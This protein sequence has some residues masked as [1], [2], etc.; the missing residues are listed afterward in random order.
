HPVSELRVVLLGNSWSGRSSVGNFI[1]GEPVFN[2]DEEPNNC[3]RIGGQLKEGKIFLINTP[4]LLNPNISEDKLREHVELCVRLS[5]P[6]P[7]VFLLVLQPEDFTEE[8]RLRLCRVLERFSDQSFDHSMVLMSKPKQKSPASRDFNIH[9]APLQEMISICGFR[10]LKQ[11]DLEL[12][13][14]LKNFKQIVEKNHGN[15]V[16][17]HQ[18]TIKHKE[19]SV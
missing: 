12:R 19:E 1:L 7:H 8:H 15:H 2:T 3:L 4:D 16:M 18:L 14:L 13:E 17:C 5:V 6:G 11:E 10:S 9:Q